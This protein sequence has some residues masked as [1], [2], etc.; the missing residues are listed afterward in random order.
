MAIELRNSM[1]IHVPS[2]V[3]EQSNVKVCGWQS[4]W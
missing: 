4:Y 2:V 1:F 3:V